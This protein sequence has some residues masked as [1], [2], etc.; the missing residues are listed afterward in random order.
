[1]MA[2]IATLISLRYISESRHAGAPKQ[3]RARWAVI[4][5]LAKSHYRELATAGSAQIFAQAIRSGR[6]IIVPLYG[7]S[8]LGLDIAAIG[9]I[10]SISAAIDMSLFIP[11]GIIMDRLGRKY[12]S[13]PSFAVMAIGMAMVPFAG[14]FVGLLAATA[15]LGLGNGLGSGAMMTLGA[16]LAP[17]E[18]TG[19]FLGVWRLVGDSGSAGGPVLVGTIA[20]VLGLSYA[21]FALAGIG[22]FAAGTL[23]FFVK[24]TL[25]TPE[26]EPAKQET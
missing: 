5:K 26:P 19:E 23:W 22:I 4:G 8:V 24:E 2:L 3:S 7:A 15:V 21:A 13:V 25:A 6:Q 11:A 10:V 14:D 9:T 1:V 18:A 12:A 17:K 20:D 16:D